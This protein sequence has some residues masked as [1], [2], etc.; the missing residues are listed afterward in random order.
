MNPFAVILSQLKSHPEMYN[1]YVPM[2]YDEYIKRM[3]K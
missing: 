1:G 2:G 3:S